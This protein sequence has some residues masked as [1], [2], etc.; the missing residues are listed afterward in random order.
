MYCTHW[1]PDGPQT[2]IG[3][4]PM[5]YILPLVCDPQHTQKNREERKRQLSPTMETLSGDLPLQCPEQCQS[6]IRNTASVTKTEC[7]SWYSRHL[8]PQYNYYKSS[9]WVDAPQGWGTWEAVEH[10]PCQ[11]LPL[12]H[13]SLR[14]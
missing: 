10:C 13:I 9:S 7:T 14:H 2:Y 5:H 8:H 6:P 11:S 12:C 1:N 3:L 4:H